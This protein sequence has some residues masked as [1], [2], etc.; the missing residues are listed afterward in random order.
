MSRPLQVL[1]SA[2]GV[3]GLLALGA[4][5][6]HRLQPAHASH[7]ARPSSEVQTLAEHPAHA[8]EPG[9]RMPAPP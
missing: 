9:T 6:I 8:A 1:M 7:P 4:F 2:A 5:L 3:A